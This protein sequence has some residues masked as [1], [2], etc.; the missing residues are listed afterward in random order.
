M[1]KIVLHLATSL[2]GFITGAGDDMETPWDDAA[3][4]AR[5]AARR[6]SRPGITPP[7]APIATG[8]DPTRATWR[9]H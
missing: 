3:A 9:S 2:D 6:Q 7:I 4:G 5:L 8:R 1:G